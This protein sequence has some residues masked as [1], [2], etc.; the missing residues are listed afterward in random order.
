[1]SRE[2]ASVVGPGEFR[3]Y[4]LC[5]ITKAIVANLRSVLL[6][7]LQGGDVDRRLWVSEFHS[8]QFV[9]KDAGDR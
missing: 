6:V 7:E 4:W 1:M 5:A 2:I 9:H 8:L 3:G